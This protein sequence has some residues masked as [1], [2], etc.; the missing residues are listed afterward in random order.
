MSISPKNSGTPNENAAAAQVAANLANL[1]SQA[2]GS[3][4][5]TNEQV[6][7]SNEHGS[8]AYLADIKASR[9]MWAKIALDPNQ[10]EETRKEAREN[11]AR[12]DEYAREHDKDNKGLLQKLAKN[13]AELIG[14][15]A[16]ATLGV[17]AAIANNGKIPMIQL[18]K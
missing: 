5:E 7:K 18:K 17:V 6:I 2:T 15:V 16:V 13:K 1:T 4:D 10:S 9:E 8:D 14:T 3:M 12:I 11:M